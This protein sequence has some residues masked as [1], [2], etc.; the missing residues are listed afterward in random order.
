MHSGAGWKSVGLSENHLGWVKISSSGVGCFKSKIHNADAGYAASAIACKFKWE[1]NSVSC[2]SLQ[3]KEIK[4]AMIRERENQ[5]MWRRIIHYEQ[6][7]WSQHLQKFL[8]MNK[9]SWIYLRLARFSFAPPTHSFHMLSSRAKLVNE[10]HN[11]QQNINQLFFYESWTIPGKNIGCVTLPPRPHL[12]RWQRSKN[13]KQTLFWHFFG[14][15]R[16][17]SPLDCEIIIRRDFPRG[18][19]CLHLEKGFIPNLKLYAGYSFP[20]WILESY[21]SCTYLMKVLCSD[22]GRWIEW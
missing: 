21:L 6:H 11:N 5:K 12:R 13:T 2:K 10:K 22:S 4:H 1:S 7:S 8:R 16:C 15:R 18:K 14:H 19:L 9:N 3:C 20:V 17:F